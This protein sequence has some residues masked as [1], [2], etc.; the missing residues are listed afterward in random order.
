MNNQE[1]VSLTRGVVRQ[2]ILPDWYQEPQQA[3]VVP[4]P[5]IN[6]QEIF[7]EKRARLEKMQKQFQKSGS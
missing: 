3:Q 6:P 4:L 5:G 2:E 7:E 1:R